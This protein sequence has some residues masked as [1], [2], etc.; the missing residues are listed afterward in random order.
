MGESRSSGTTGSS[1]GSRAGRSTRI[2]AVTAAT[3]GWVSNRSA[4]ARS[5]PGSHQVSSSQKAR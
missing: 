4:A 1:K 5:E 2:R 3:S